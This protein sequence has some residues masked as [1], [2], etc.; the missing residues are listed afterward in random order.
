[1]EVIKEFG[2]RFRTLRKRLDMTQTEF[3]KDFNQKYNRAFTT[4]AVS[5]YENGKRIPEIDA[6]INFAEYFGVSVDYLLGADEKPLTPSST[7]QN[8]AE[9]WAQLNED[10]RREAFNY[11]QYLKTKRPPEGDPKG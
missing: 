2:Y 3:I 4:A 7:D 11:I 1:M 5:Q 10:Q 8:L 9:L 6:L